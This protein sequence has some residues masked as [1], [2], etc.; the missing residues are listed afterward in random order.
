[1]SGRGNNFVY[2][3]DDADFSMAIQLIID[4]KKRLSVCN[5]VDKVLVNKQL[6]G[7]EAKVELLTEALKIK[8]GNSGDG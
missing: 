4:G 1:M 2:I 7:L 6:E 5:A 8:P 3:H